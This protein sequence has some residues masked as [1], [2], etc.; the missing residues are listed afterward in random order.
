MTT[1]DVNFL[2]TVTE[3]LKNDGFAVFHIDYIGGAGHQDYFLVNSTAELEEVIS[4]IEPGDLV[5]VFMNEAIGI[6]GKAEDILQEQAIAML[7]ELQAEDCD[8]CV[9][10]FRRDTNHLQLIYKDDWQPL[11]SAMEIKEWFAKNLN[12][13]I[14]VFAPPWNNSKV[15]EAK[16]ARTCW[17]AKLYFN[18]DLFVMKAI[19]TIF[20]SVTN[21]LI[22]SLKSSRFGSIIIVCFIMLISI[23]LISIPG[24]LFWRLFFNQLRYRHVLMFVTF[25]I[26]FLSWHSFTRN[27]RERYLLLR[28]I[29][30]I[31][32]L[33]FIAIVILFL[34]GVI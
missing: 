16:G 20:D 30:H 2:S 26:A 4:R 33:V 32:A 10:A 24:C 3:S 28:I 19:S 34:A 7:S 1:E 6:K 29:E 21:Y 25:I 17:L 27:L 8:E 9:I 22:K 11:C 14:I 5:S 13:P 18:F 15:L 31:I 23:A 12:A